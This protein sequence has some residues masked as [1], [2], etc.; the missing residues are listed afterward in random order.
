ML[1]LGA[2]T[3]ESAGAMKAWAGGSTLTKA[4]PVVNYACDLLTA[5]G[6]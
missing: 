2:T 4:D 3:A 5:V 6:G 1:S